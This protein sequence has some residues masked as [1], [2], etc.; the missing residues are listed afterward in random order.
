MY[1]KSVEETEPE[2]KN[3]VHEHGDG[4][5]SRVWGRG[6]MN[7]NKTKRKREHRGRDV[8]E[9]GTDGYK[10]ADPFF[11]GSGLGK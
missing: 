1:I 11:E 7:N 5:S 6:R 8:V 9:G 10:R 4:L 3:C 2:S